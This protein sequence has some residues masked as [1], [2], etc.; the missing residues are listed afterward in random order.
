[1]FQEAHSEVNLKHRT[2]KLRHLPKRSRCHLG[3]NSE[4]QGLFSADERRPPR[5]TRLLMFIGC[6]PVFR[7]W[8]LRS[9]YGSRRE[10]S[11]FLGFRETLLFAQVPTE[12]EF[13]K[14]MRGSF[15]Q[16]IGG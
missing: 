9:F 2:S 7:I 4:T 12:S 14:G 8:G 1:M 3:P 5:P 6:F 10:S 16:N 11:K 13:G 15:D